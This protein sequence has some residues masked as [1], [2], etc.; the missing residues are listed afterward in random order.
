MSQYVPVWI[1]VGVRSNKVNGDFV[2]YLVRLFN[3]LPD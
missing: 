2:R 1:N 3:Q